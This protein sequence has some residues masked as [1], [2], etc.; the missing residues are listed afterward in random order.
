MIQPPPG[1]YTTNRE[2][3]DALVNQSSSCMGC[4]TSVINPPGYRARELRR[5]RR[6]AD[7]RPARQDRSTRS[8]TVNFGDGNIKQIN[9]AQ[10]LMQQLAQTPKGAEHVR[11]ELGRL[12]RMGGIRTR[13]TSASPI[14]SAPSWRQT[15]TAILNVLADLTQADSFRLRVRATP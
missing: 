9:N 5:H 11:A 6:V 14:R 12:R 8:P 2:K 1:N 4:H 7:G 13:T 3:T 10:E 15:A